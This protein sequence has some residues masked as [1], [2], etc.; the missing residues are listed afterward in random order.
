[1]VNEVRAHFPGPVFENVV[2]RSV[3]LAEAPSFGKSILDF[4]AFSKGARAYKGVAREII[5]REPS[6]EEEEE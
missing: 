5:A 1:M 4:D 6:K 3:R 2:P